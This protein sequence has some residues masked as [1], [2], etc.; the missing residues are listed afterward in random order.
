MLYAISLKWNS[1]GQSVMFNTHF[2]TEYY[3]KDAFYLYY[4]YN[5]PTAFLQ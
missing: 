3:E 4:L 1:Y 2:R 5:D